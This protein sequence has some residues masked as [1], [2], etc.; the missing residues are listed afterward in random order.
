MKYDDYCYE[1][2][3]LKTERNRY[4]TQNAETIAEAMDSGIILEGISYL[5]DHDRH[6]HVKVGDIDGIIP[7]GECALRLSESNGTNLVFREQFFQEEMPSVTVCERRS[8]IL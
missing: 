1:G 5:C 6:L 2:K 4:Y 3:R 8:A 7:H